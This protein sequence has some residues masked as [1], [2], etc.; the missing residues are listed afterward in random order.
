MV[1]TSNPTPPCLPSC[2]GSSLGVVL[3]LVACLCCLHGW[4]VLLCLF[5]D[6]FLVL[7][8][9]ALLLAIS[10]PKYFV[11]SSNLGGLLSLLLF[12]LVVS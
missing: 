6:V 11:F 5:P 12:L 1:G 2:M 10:L 4:L 7:L 8:W 9:L 3:V